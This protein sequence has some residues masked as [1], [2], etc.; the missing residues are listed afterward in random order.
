MPFHS[1]SSVILAKKKSQHNTNNRGYR[2][3]G[4]LIRIGSGAIGVTSGR[5]FNSD[6]CGADGRGLLIASRTFEPNSYNGRTAVWG[7]MGGCWWAEGEK[8]EFASLS[9]GRW[10]HSSR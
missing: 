10:Q 1:V 2:P 6:Y 3:S 8:R 9:I 7:A 4:S 5:I